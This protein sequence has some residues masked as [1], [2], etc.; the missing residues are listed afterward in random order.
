MD[1]IEHKEVILTQ[2]AA[3]EALGITRVTCHYYGSGDEGS[4]D[5]FEIEPDTFTEEQ[6]GLSPRGGWPDTNP[7][8]HA[9]DCLTFAEV[10]GDNAGGGGEIAVDV[11]AKT[12]TRAEYYNVES[13]EYLG[14]QVL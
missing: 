1:G 6:A 10:S 14:E 8:Y 3:W 13:Q 9:F 11:K 5:R 7:I 12:I 4:I 2:C